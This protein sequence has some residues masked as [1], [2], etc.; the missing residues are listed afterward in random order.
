MQCSNADLIQAVINPALVGAQLSYIATKQ[1]WAVN[2]PLIRMFDVI[3]TDPN[4]ELVGQRNLRKEQQAKDK[5]KKKAGSSRQSVSTNSSSSSGERGFGLLSTRSRKKG[6]TTSG[7]KT[8]PSPLSQEESSKVRAPRA[9]TYGVKAALDNKEELDI[10]PKLIEGPFLPV[11]PPGLEETFPRSPRD[12]ALSKWAHHAAIET[13]VFERIAAYDTSPETKV[14]TYVQTLGPSSFITQVIETTVSPRTSEADI[15]KFFIETHISSDGSKIQ[16]LPQAPLL[17]NAASE[18]CEE[19][20][21]FPHPPHIYPQTPPPMENR[22]N[23]ISSTPKCEGHDRLG[24]AEAWKPPHEWDCTPTKQAT[25]TA[26]NERL[27][28]SPASPQTHNSM[29]P[30][31]AVVQRQLRMMAAASPELMLSNM[32]TNMRV[33][34]DARVYKEL[35]MTRKRWMFSALQQQSGYAQFIEQPNDRTGSPTAPKRNRILALYE[36][37]ASASFLAALHQESFIT[38][39]SPNPLSPDLFPSVQPLLVPSISVSAGSRA[40]PPKLYSTVTCLSMPALFPSTDIPPLLSHINRCLAPGGA[41][42]L[43]IIDPQPVSASMGPK[44]RQWLFTH[45]LINLEQEFRT[46]WPSETF[47]A[48]LAA[49]NLRGKGSTIATIMVPAVPDGP[50]KADAKTELRCLVNRLLWQEVWGGF[51]HAQQWWWDEEEIVQE[52]IDMGTQWQYS[53]IVAVKEDRS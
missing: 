27:R 5:D 41:L 37:Q 35:E 4:V 24:N 18:L 42:Y 46:T 48:W 49:G 3:W 40:L 2:F 31:F 30:S 28:M 19:P 36:T 38:H 39:L 11:Q 9:S 14:E 12:S 15:D 23:Y 26:I 34:S 7:G 6:S 50:E 32:R 21:S 10:P 16:S 17:E 47:P 44:L 8:T 13:G 20:E 33:A 53:H 1:N 22:S 45:L 25:T 43:T 51:V 29:S 52:C